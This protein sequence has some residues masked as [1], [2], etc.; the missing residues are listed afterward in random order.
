MSL[1]QVY[2]SGVSKVMTEHNGE[3]HSDEIKWDTDYDG[4]KANVLL[5]INKDGKKM[6]RTLQ[7]SNDDIMQMLSIPSVKTPLETRLLQDFLPQ[8]SFLK[9]SIQRR[10]KKNMKKRRN[11]HKKRSIKTLKRK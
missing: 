1:V 4:N 2:S 3:K 9:R 10:S 5:N 6:H 11:T 7:L 8:T